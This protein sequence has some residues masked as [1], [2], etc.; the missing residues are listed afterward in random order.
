MVSPNLIKKSES[1]SAINSNAKK[2][3]QL[4]LGK[5]QKSAIRSFDDDIPRIHVSH[6][7]SRLS[8]LY[9]KIRNAVDYDDE[10]LLRKNAIKRLL[11]RYI[12]IE[13]IVKNYNSEELSLNLLTELI[14]AGYLPNDKIPESKIKEVAG[15]LDKY[16]ALKSN[17]KKLALKGKNIDDEL[18]NDD[19]E[20]SRMI[21]WIITLAA[22]EVEGNL[23]Q[24]DVRQLIV[25]NMYETLSRIIKLPSDLPYQKD[26]DI[27]IY[28]SIARNF[29]N[30]DEEMLGFI[31]FKYYNNWSE[32]SEEELVEVARSLKDIN[33]AVEY[34]LK[35]PLTKQIDKIVRRY[36]LY[37]TIFREIAEEDPAKNY[38]NAASNT[39]AFISLIKEKC[40]KKYSVVKNRLW[41]SGFRSIVY[42]FLTKSIFVFLLEIPA[43]NLFGEK[44]NYFAL[45]INIS[46]PALLLLIVIMFTKTPNE[47]NTEKIIDGIKEIVYSDNLRRQPIY[48][49]KIT[50]RNI[51]ATSIFNA[52][53]SLAFVISVTLLVCLLYYFV[54]F[55]WV[56]IVIFL[57][58]L[59]FVSF[60]SFRIKRDVRRY[61][62]TDDKE[63]IFGFIFQFFYMPIV[64]VGKFL[65]DNVS[66][67]NIFVFILDF[68]IETPFKVIV[69]IVEEWSKYLKEREEDLR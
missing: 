62:I 54:D 48:L 3:F 37:Y 69:G 31:V 38:E 68:I 5:K 7:V 61:V 51:V 67:V 59:T 35:H 16:I 65:S 46:F 47:K 34:Q 30:L 20:G 57:F 14:Q 8:F 60:F 33:A 27:Q 63:T 15:L 1:G 52:I 50:K 36:T 9:E 23:N 13:G 44:I 41:G 53:Y 64:A 56:S 32:I 19:S 66:R 22:T 49:R 2:I 26:L 45:M 40:Q 58:F 24:D 28:L 43:I 42:I 12:L 17:Y 55:N 4:I 18:K 10:H 11:K 39:K 25:S 21:N 29:L 6:I